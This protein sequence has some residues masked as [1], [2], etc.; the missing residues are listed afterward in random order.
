MQLIKP[1][2]GV[3]LAL[4]IR[5]H[6]THAAPAVDQ[7]LIVPAG[8]A[9]GF[10][11]PV[12]LPA[13][14]F[15]VGVSGKL[16]RVDLAIGGVS[17]VADVNVR[18]LGTIGGVPVMH[19]EL[20]MV[21][22][23]GEALPNLGGWFTT[24]RLPVDLSAFNIKVNEGDVLAISAQSTAFDANPFAF[25]WWDTSGMYQRG[26]AYSGHTEYSQYFPVMGAELDRGFATYVVVPEPDAVALLLAA[27]IGS[28]RPLK[29][30]EG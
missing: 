16:S 13:Q 30:W 14:T 29:S 27:L 28:I 3:A 9:T 22:L 19:Q 10:S 25:L 21:T 8:H 2:V 12:H 17:Q 4:C 18:I 6:F 20:A 26:R 5:S 24:P 7:S 1:F 23:P 11:D 15:T